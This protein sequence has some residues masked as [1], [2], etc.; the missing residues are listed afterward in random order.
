MPSKLEFKSS[1]THSC[2]WTVM[3][4]KQ[5]SCVW[6]DNITLKFKAGCQKHCGGGGSVESSIWGLADLPSARCLL[7]TSRH[8]THYVST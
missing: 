5:F 7:D 1:Q 2:V 4:L 6:Q 8:A 3:P